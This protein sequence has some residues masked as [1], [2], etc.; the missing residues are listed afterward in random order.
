M[1]ALNFDF[2]R[3]TKDFN[4]YSRDNKYSRYVEVHTTYLLTV[5][6]NA[7]MYVLPIENF[8]GK[9]KIENR[10]DHYSSFECIQNCYKTIVSSLEQFPHSSFQKRIVSA[11]TIRGNT[12]STKINSYR[13]L[14][15][16]G[17]NSNKFSRPVSNRH[18]LSSSLFLQFPT[19]P[20]TYASPKYLCTF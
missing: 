17:K 13:V 9:R 6:W 2:A 11:E 7:D 1:V 18:C 12:V 10:C 19:L 4:L 15:Y 14:N 5:F 8:C 3:S 20:T 16:K